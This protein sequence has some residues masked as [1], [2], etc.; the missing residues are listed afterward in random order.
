[1]A[2]NILGKNTAILM[3]YAGGNGSGFWL[4]PDHLTRMVFSLTWR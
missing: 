4:L 3:F 1:M 2:T